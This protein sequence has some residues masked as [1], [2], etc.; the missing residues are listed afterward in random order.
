MLRKRLTCSQPRDSTIHGL[1]PGPG[2]SLPGFGRAY[3]RKIKE[4][5]PPA[6][7]LSGYGEGLPFYSNYVEIDPALC[8]RHR[9]PQVDSTPI[10]NTR[11]LSQY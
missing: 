6:V 7:H 5:Y 9:I 3:K 11:V 8:D 2:A 10:R 4:L 1:G